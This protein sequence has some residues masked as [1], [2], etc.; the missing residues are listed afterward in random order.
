MNFSF[1]YDDIGEKVSYLIFKDA[2]SELEKKD[3][4]F[5]RCIS[6]S[7]DQ[8]GEKKLTVEQL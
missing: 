3:S 4:S 2:E 6:I 5:K 1:D 7:S 8:S